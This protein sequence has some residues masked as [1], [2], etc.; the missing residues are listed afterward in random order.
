MRLLW[1]PLILW[2][3]ARLAYWT[4][5]LRREEALRERLLARSLSDDGL[6]WNALARV[7]RDGWGHDA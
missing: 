3:H 5:R 6:D 1:L 2:Q 7:N 4:R